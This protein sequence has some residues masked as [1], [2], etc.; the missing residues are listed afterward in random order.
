V[1]TRDF[2][3]KGEVQELRPAWKYRLNESTFY[4]E[5]RPSRGRR[6]AVVQAM[7]VRAEKAQDEDLIAFR[8]RDVGPGEMNLHLPLSRVEVK[9]QEQWEALWVNGEPI[10]DDGYDLE[11]R[12]L[13]DRGEGMGEY[14]VRWYNPVPGGVYRFV[15]EPRQGHPAL[16]SQPVIHG[17]FTAAVP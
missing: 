2:L 1:L 5:S 6:D 7:A 15:I 4:P 12:Y 16:I 14:E 17:G 9:N 13:A 3:A 10:H 8:W 11:V